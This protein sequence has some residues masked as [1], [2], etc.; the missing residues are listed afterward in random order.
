MAVI[1]NAIVALQIKGCLTIEVTC[2]TIT[3]TFNQHIFICDVILMWAYTRDAIVYVLC[4][5]LL[6]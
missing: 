5:N 2:V 3:L 1:L 6:V 4:H